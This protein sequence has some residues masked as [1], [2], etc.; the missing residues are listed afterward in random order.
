MQVIVFD[1]K[2]KGLDVPASAAL[3]IEEILEHRAF[4]S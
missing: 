4:K 1:Y 2:R 3:L